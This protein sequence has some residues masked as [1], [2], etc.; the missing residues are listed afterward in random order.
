MGFG[1]LIG[2]LQPC[3]DRER[4]R[5]REKERKKGRKTERTKER[6]KEIVWTYMMTILCVRKRTI[7]SHGGYGQGQVTALSF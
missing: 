3:H 1:G 7:R 2:L 6:K 4:E 5:E